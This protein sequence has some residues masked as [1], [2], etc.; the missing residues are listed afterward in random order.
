LRTFEGETG[1]SRETALIHYRAAVAV[2]RIEEFDERL[3]AVSVDI[4]T[5]GKDGKPTFRFKD[6]SEIT[7]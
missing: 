7:P 2:F 6:G 4:V 5:V 1:M 3:W